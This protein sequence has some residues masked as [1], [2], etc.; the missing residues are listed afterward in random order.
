MKKSRYMGVLV[1]RYTLSERF[2]MALKL[3]FSHGYTPDYTIEQLYS[4]VSK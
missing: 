4:E 2:S 3:L 1:N